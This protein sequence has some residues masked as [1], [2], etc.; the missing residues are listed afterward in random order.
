MQPFLI[1]GGMIAARKM[2]KNHPMAVTCYSNLLL[3]VV[4]V[5]GIQ[6]H[7]SI[8][9]EFFGSLSIWSWVLIGLAGLMTIFET[10]LKFL[11]FRYEEAAKLQKLA[12][13]P[14]VW[15]FTID[16]LFLN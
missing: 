5:I 2:K 14:N 16:G 1:A 11:A 15:N 10:T 3:G 6:S 4:S 13:M 7:D 8:S 9:F 12:F